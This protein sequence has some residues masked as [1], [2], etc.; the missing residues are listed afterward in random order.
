MKPNEIEDIEVDLLLE[1]I[2]R[3]YGY[4]FRSYARASV[5]RR[6]RQFVNRAGLDS[7]AE[8]IPV[9]LRDKEAF[10]ELVRQFSISVTEMFRD[11]LVYRVLRQQVLPLLQ[12]YPFVKAWAAGCATG[13]EVYSLAVVFAEAGLLERSTIYGTDFNDDALRQAR[14][15][16]Y[17]AA[18]MQEFTR[19]YQEGGGTGSFAGYYRAG[20]GL[21]TLN[22]RLKERITFAN[23]NLTTD[24]VFGEMHLVSCRNVLIYFNRELADRALRIFTESLVHGGFLVL[25][26]KE[27]L[28]FTAV[29]GEYEVVDRAARIFR[30]RGT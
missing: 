6:V 15:G 20:Q 22:A 14:M 29:A 21:A 18:Q 26:A 25:G 16:V 8:L 13:E 27:D 12:T 17:T 1:A 2:Y 30:K 28:Q 11:P 24:H 19:N 9:I 23:H 7:I 5:D 3:R 4:D 10:S